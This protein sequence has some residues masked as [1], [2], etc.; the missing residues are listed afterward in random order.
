VLINDETTFLELMR[1]LLVADEGYEV[2]IC[3]E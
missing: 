3:N 1:D 2:S